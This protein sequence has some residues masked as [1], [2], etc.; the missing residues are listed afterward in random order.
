MSHPKVT[1]IVQYKTFATIE[2]QDLYNTFDINT[3]T[4]NPNN[5][6]AVLIHTQY[7]LKVYNVDCILKVLI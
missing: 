6:H 5:T 3:S 4:E 2:V 7:C 1:Q